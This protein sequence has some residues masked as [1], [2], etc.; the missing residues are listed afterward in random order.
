MS[1]ASLKTMI[2]SLI[3]QDSRYGPQAYF[4][5]LDSLDF[6]SDD[7]GKNCLTGDE[8]HVSVEE[9]LDGV[10][11]F[12]LTQYGP[13][14]RIVLEHYGIYST[15]DVGEIVFNMVEGGL[16]NSQ[17]T[18][19]RLDFVDVYDFREVFE[20]SYTPEIPW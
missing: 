9:L 3:S 1:G 17:E 19:S 12:A 10:R 8:R 11:E 6:I 5:I 14:A 7:L 13:L 15:E 16:L 18:D 2:N 20:E 4:F